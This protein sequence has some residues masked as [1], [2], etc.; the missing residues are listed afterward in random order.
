MSMSANAATT[1]FFDNFNDGIILDNGWSGDYFET[2]DSSSVSNDVSAQSG[3]DAYEGH[4]ARLEDDV[5]IYHSVSTVGYNNI[6]ISYCRKTS[7]TD[8][9]DRLRTGWKTGS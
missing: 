3:G 7:Y 8:S 1:L 4:S 6:N 9:S 2:P 5:A